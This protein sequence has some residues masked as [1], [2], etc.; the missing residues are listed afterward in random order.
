M[1]LDKLWACT[2]WSGF[3]ITWGPVNAGALSWDRLT[4]VWLLPVVPG[5]VA[6]ASGGLV[7]QRCTL[8]AARAIIRACVYLWGI[9]VPLALMLI[10]LYLGRLAIHKLP[11]KELIVSSF[12]PV[13]PLA[14][15]SLALL[16]LSTAAVRFDDSSPVMQR[17]AA[18]L[19]ETGLVAALLLWGTSTWWLVVAVASVLN[20]IHTMPFNTGWW[21]F[22]FPMGVLSQ[23][24][25]VLSMPSKLDSGVFKVLGAFFSAVTVAMWCVVATCTIVH[26][27]R[28]GHLF[29]AP[30]LIEEHKEGPGGAPPA[31]G[32]LGLPTRGAGLASD[33]P[34]DGVG[35]DL[36]LMEGGE[37]GPDDSSNGSHG[38]SKG[39][40][41]TH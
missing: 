37:A 22:V 10:T 4:A 39:G 9:S 28:G 6:A 27:L 24:T 35:P 32:A 41:H 30:C 14:M 17:F 29:V 7:A 12:L 5:V 15:S 33:L 31:L 38:G 34:A 23:T 18:A 40:W 20:S 11:P 1:V 21:G 19:E 25:V 36:G 3:T 2:R 26:R 16:H 13:G 8:S